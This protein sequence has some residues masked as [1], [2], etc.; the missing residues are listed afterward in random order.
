MIV[1]CDKCGEEFHNMLKE[2]E[3][4][5]DGFDVIMTYHQCPHCYEIYP[6]CLDT[7]ETNSVKKQ[8]RKQMKELQK[9]HNPKQ[10]EKKLAGIKKRQKW[11]QN[12]MSQLEAKYLQRFMEELKDGRTD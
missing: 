10:Y 11:L 1:T 7:A 6:I 2:K 5:I 3:I 4:T 8:I 9:I 12:K